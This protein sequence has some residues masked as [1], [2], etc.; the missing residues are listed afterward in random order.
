MRSANQ[1][2]YFRADG[3]SKMGLGHIIRSLA[4]AEMLNKTFNCIF[5]S[6]L[7]VKELKNEILSVCTDLIELQESLIQE[8]EAQYLIENI[9]NENDI[10]VLDGYHFDTEYQKLIYNHSKSLVC[11]DDIHNYHFISDI[12]INHAGGIKK[13][14]YSAEC[15]SQFCL[16]PKF[17]LLR[18]AFLKSQLP[19]KCNESS[20]KLFI[21]LGGADPDNATKRILKECLSKLNFE[22]I[23]VIIGAAYKFKNELLVLANEFKPR[24]VVLSNLKADEMA[25]YMSLCNVAITSPS[26]VCYE[27]LSIGGRLYLY[28]IAENQRRIKDYLINSGKANNYTEIFSDFRNGFRSTMSSNKLID[29]KQNIRLNRVFNA[30]SLDI[31]YATNE[32]LMLLFNWANDDL[33]RE[34]SYSQERINLE[35]HRSWFYKKLSS[36]KTS[37][38]ILQLKDIP[39]GYVRFDVIEGQE[40]VIS[41]AVDKKY[42]GNGYGESMLRK[43][44]LFIQKVADCKYSISGYVKKNNYA[45]LKAFQSLGFKEINTSTYPNSVKFVS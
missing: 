8:Q 20:Y 22:R 42:R 27:Y 23:Y 30:L 28:L 14:D 37:I 13:A 40:A 1:N 29:G 16:G 9:I 32:D 44:L 19:K 39:I 35:D 33:V 31:R 12:I 17:A 10:V 36:D 4:L 3:H 11:V 24:I 26:T 38:F 5:V 45:S 7:I 21:C 25:Y 2:V 43:A 6:R 15:Y 18:Q 34:Q 41:Y